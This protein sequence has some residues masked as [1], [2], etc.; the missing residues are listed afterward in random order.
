[1]KKFLSVFVI[2]TVLATALVA[3]QVNVLADDFKSGLVAHYDFNEI[4][5]GVVKDVSGNG[6]DGTY[7][8]VSAAT[9]NVDGAVEITGSADGSWYDNTEA[10]RVL[11]PSEAFTSE[12]I[13][14]AILLKAD[15]SDVDG[16]NCVVMTSGAAW[17]V[18]ANFVNFWLNHDNNGGIGPHMAIQPEESVERSHLRTEDD[19]VEEDEWTWL[20]YTQANGEGVFYLNGYEAASGDMDNSIADIIA[21]GAGDM[22][23]G[24]SSIFPG[25]DSFGGLVD[26]VLI[27]NR[28]LTA[29]EA[30][31][32][33]NA[34]QAPAESATPDVIEGDATAVPESAEPTA[35]PDVTESETTENTA[36][37]ESATTAPTTSPAKTTTTAPSATPGDDGD[38]T[39][40]ILPIIIVVIVVVVVAAAGLCYYFLVVKK[41]K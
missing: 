21:L 35:T 9:G 15:F 18:Q 17:D 16:N 32:I 34:V 11:L 3:G 41:K 27:Y 2:L 31:N 30:K 13:T 33:N 24:T 7:Q 29:S 4:K 12:D 20:V 6:H 25:D 19:M 36:T 37:A 39:G 10:S 28:A 8:N 26:E 5:D 23:I 38:N 22:C 40:N 1:M 14:I